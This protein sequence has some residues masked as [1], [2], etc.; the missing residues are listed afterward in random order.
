[1]VTAIERIE[2]ESKESAARLGDLRLDATGLGEFD[3]AKVNPVNPDFNLAQLNNEKEPIINE[4]KI[5]FYL[6]KDPE[7]R[8]KILQARE[9]IRIILNE[10]NKL[11]QRPEDVEKFVEEY[12]RTNNLTFNEIAGRYPDP[13]TDF[14]MALTQGANKTV[15]GLLDQVIDL[16]YLVTPT[17]TLETT[18]QKFNPD[19]DFVPSNEK[20]K[21]KLYEIF[22]FLH[23]IDPSFTADTF[24]ERVADNMGK[25]IVE[26]IP[27]SGALTMV[28]K[29]NKIVV[30]DPETLKGIYS[31]AKNNLSMMYNQIIDIYDEA[32]KTGQLGKVVADDILAVMGFS[33]GTDYANEISKGLE[34]GIIGTPLELITRT[35]GPF[36]GAGVFVKGKQYLY[37]AP[38]AMAG[39]I[40]NWSKN[41]AAFN[42]DKSTALAK[43]KADEYLNDNPG[44]ID[45]A[46]RVY[47]NSLENPEQGNIVSNIYQYYKGKRDNKKNAEIA[48]NIKQQINKDEIANRQDALDVEDR[49]NKFVVQVVEQGPDGNDRIVQKIVNLREGEGPSLD[50]TLAQATKSVPLI[51]SQQKIESDLINSAFTLNLKDQ[52]LK[53]KVGDVIKEKSLSNYKV[54][55]DAVQREFPDKQFVYTTVQNEDGTQSIVAV[56][57]K[58]GNFYSYFNTNNRAGGLVDEQIDEQLAAQ[59]DILTPGSNIKQKGDVAES[60]AQIRSNYEA[61]K[62]GAQN[63]YNKKLLELVDDS[64]G[65]NKLD[66]SDFK[67]TV[68]TK[69]K[70]EDFD[71]PEDIPQAFYQIRDLGNDFLPIINKYTTQLQ[72]SYNKY[73]ENPTEYN[74]KVYLEEIKKLEKG[75]K[76][77]LN[78]M[79]AKLQKDFESGDRPIAPIYEMGDITFNYGANIKFNDQGKVIGGVDEAGKFYM[80]RKLKG[81]GKQDIGIGVP[82]EK[83]TVSITDPS[84]EIGIK[85]LINLKQSVQRDLN[86]ALR[87]PSENSELI[88]RQR[89]ILEEIDK[90]ITDNL[91]GIQA[92]D[93][94]LTQKT[95][96]YTDIYE[97]GQILKITTQDGTGQYVLPDE[98]VGKAFL[99]NPQSIDEFF[100]TMGDN[101]S[102]VLGLE[103]AF[104][105]D[106][107]KKVL[108]KDGLIDINKLKNFRKNNVDIITKLDEYIPIS[109]T[110]D[111]QIKLGVTAANR[112]K[113]LNDRKKFADF[114]ELDNFLKDGGLG[115]KL[116]FK[117]PDEMVKQALKDPE[118]MSDIVKTLSKVEGRDQD[119]LLTA[120][121]N[122]VFEKFLNANI[123]PEQ[124]AKGA[125]P[126]TD[127]MTAFLNKNEES[128]KA[129]YKATGDPDGYQRLKDI[130]EAYYRLNLTGFPQKKQ[131]VIPNTVERIF[132]TGIPQ[133]LSRVFAVQSG[134]TSFR[135]VTTEL[136]MRFMQQLNTSA[137]EK[138]IAAALYDKKNA[139]ALLTMLEGKSLN[140]SQVNRL[141]AMFGKAYGF[142]GTTVND[143]IGEIEKPRIPYGFDAFDAPPDEGGVQIKSDA[144]R[145][146]D[147]KNPRI[148]K[149]NIPDASIA[150]TLSNVNMSKMTQN[151]I[152]NTLARGQAIFGQDDPIFGGIAAV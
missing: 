49:L 75:L 18:Y 13:E 10:G 34:P 62:I 16:N 85:S 125:E 150:S 35:F 69:I 129:F 22:E 17:G 99:N 132:G 102:A 134:R 141:K 144:Q 128:I 11:E 67:D 25:F 146:R 64:F 109:E 66:I 104:Y 114:I 124:L 94:W 93:D 118:I 131:D 12:I 87:N 38:I 6:P 47:Q 98:A 148:P 96:N 73:L 60:G 65:G 39:A 145:L 147:D 68:I 33:A 113:I 8:E 19:I 115:T 126:D 108:D 42:Q 28:N 40:K 45:G 46:A 43:Q 48:Y 136:G 4:Q 56:E 152:P 106:M 89:I 2:G 119:V 84:M 123:K 55:S 74:Y 95:K 112:I 135:F 81:K 86:V 61:Q 24:E 107:F 97:K 149:L 37:D 138:I 26:S 90:V 32:K 30:K 100:N 59:T 71:R 14:I 54:V 117:N 58:V 23:F 29:A 80:G 1:M 151:T 137:R 57:Q 41:F 140:L 76:S 77:E 110:L 31:K 120:F 91:G 116:V 15:K 20:A 130:T 7:K 9:D 105:D 27:I 44:D 51:Q 139:Q 122:K 101:P 103:A 78:G 72:G 111:S 121:K 21:N 127:A 50:F 143:E 82:G 5:D 92:Y 36:L 83:V 63:L 133:V 53:G 79:N 52:A 70:P 88:T 142:I 3:V